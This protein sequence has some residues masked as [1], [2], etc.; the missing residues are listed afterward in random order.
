MTECRIYLKYHLLLRQINPPWWDCRVK[1]KNT[2]GPNADNLPTLRRTTTPLLISPFNPECNIMH[3]TQVLWMALRESRSEKAAADDG[4]LLQSHHVPHDAQCNSSVHPCCLQVCSTRGTSGCWAE[5][6]QQKFAVKLGHPGLRESRCA[7][8]IRVAQ[9]FWRARCCSV[10]CTLYG[11]TSNQL[12]H[13]ALALSY[14]EGV[15]M[16]MHVCMHMCAYV[17]GSAWRSCSRTEQRKKI[18][19]WW[20]E[21]L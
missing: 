21:T 18:T 16:H 8:F 2:Y 10:D 12:W 4:H 3:A 20:P 13:E 5:W 19:M 7:M 9:S 15:C 14:A 1:E 17:W 6:A 11:H